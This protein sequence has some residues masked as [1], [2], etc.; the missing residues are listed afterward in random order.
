MQ[1]N[2]QTKEKGSCPSMILINAD[3]HAKQR[4]SSDTDEISL[5]SR[6]PRRKYQFKNLKTSQIKVISKLS[7]DSNWNMGR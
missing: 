7:C 5:K 4:Y 6:K 2:D 1:G 3:M